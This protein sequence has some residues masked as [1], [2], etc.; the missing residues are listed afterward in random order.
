MKVMEQKIKMEEISVF[1]L[2]DEELRRFYIVLSLIEHGYLRKEEYY[3]ELALKQIT[4]KLKKFIHWGEELAEKEPNN[5]IVYKM[6]QF[7]NRHYQLLVA[8]TKQEKS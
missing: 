4:L 2:S 1:N 7:F 5:L 3:E 8:A 6:N